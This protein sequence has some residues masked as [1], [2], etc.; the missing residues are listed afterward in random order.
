KLE[1][2]RGARIA[3][4][5][6]HA[7]CAGEAAVVEVEFEIDLIAQVLT[8]CGVRL[9]RTRASCFDCVRVRQ[10]QERTGRQQTQRKQL[11]QTCAPSPDVR[12]SLP[13]DQATTVR[14]VNKIERETQSQDKRAGGARSNAK[15]VF[16]FW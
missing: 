5:P 15:A 8:T 14:R 10:Q 4:H 1:R 9:R 3:V 13:H 6:T 16:S 2:G 7:L 12:D 11:A